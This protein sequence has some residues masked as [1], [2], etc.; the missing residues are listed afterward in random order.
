MHEE[1]TPYE[2]SLRL[3]AGFATIHSILGVAGESCKRQRTIRPN[4]T[5]DW[6]LLIV[7][8]GEYILDI[9]STNP[10]TLYPK[11]AILFPPHHRQDYT[12]SDDHPTGQMFWVHFYPEASMLEPLEWP[13]DEEGLAILQWEGNDRLGQ[14]IT[15]ACARCDSYLSSDYQ[16][17][18]TLALLSLEEIFWLISQVNPLSQLEALDDRVAATLQFIASNI[19]SPLTIQTLAEQVGLSPS[20]LSHIFAQNKHCG[21]MEHIERLRIKMACNMLL[22]TPLPINIISEECGFSSSYYFSKRFRKAKNMSPTE[23]RNTEEQ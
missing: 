15:E 20:R 8:K 19:K 3:Q 10:V 21:I 4:G 23:Y 13:K 12:L 16:R 22:N 7:L 1:L 17:N 6:H 14:Q 2:L 5:P 9:D 11:S 18:R